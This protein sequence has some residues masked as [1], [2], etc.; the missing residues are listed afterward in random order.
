MQLID[1]Q[2]TTNGDHIGTVLYAL[3]AFRN[4]DCV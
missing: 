1:M 3:T 4:Y 2:N